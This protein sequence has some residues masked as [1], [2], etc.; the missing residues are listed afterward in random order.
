MNSW[1]LGT[2]LWA[3]VGLSWLVGIV[4]TSFLIVRLQ[5]TS[6]AYDRIFLQEVRQ[7]TLIR[8]LQVGFKKQVQEW[9][10][11]LLRG[12]DPVALQK[13]RTQLT[14]QEAEVGKT[15]AELRG[16]ASDPEVRFML[17]Q[18]RESNDKLVANYAAGLAEFIKANGSNPHEVDS[19]LKGQDRP[20]TDF[21][22]RVAGLMS[23]RTSERAKAEGAIITEVVLALIVVFVLLG[24][25]SAQVVR[26]LIAMLRQAVTDAGQSAGQVAA[27]AGQLAAASQS[28]A[29]GASEQSAAI[30]E[31]SASAQDINFLAQKNSQNSQRAKD[32]IAITEDGFARANRVLDEM[33]TSMREVNC[34]SDQMSKVIKVIDGIAFQT[35]ILALN[36]AV[37]AAR[38][39]EAGMGFSVVA[40]EVRNLAQRCAQAA[41]D[42]STLIE[43]SIAKSSAGQAKVEDVTGA[44]RSITEDAVKIHNLVQEI[45]G[46][47]QEQARGAEHVARAVSEIGEITQTAAASSQET[48][49]AG[50]ELM[51]QSEAL[52]GIVSQL[53][54]LVGSAPSSRPSF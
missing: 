53:T 13:H 15:L 28:L 21:L 26:G 32:L 6:S 35:N 45:Q 24:I 19:L 50:Q 16:S 30:Q 3:L 47:S 4:S 23:H 2:R 5:T 41:R 27:A 36:A 48:A 14:Q 33:V 42:I 40:E 38:A 20:P 51:A 10:D 49:A 18:F 25:L 11:V 9:K 17:D 54:A 52:R 12:Y 1:K 37:E 34:S 31:T 44:I 39:G 7:Q 22:D 8:V 46:D 43:D 29:Q